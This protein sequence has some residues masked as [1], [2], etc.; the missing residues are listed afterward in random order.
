M[1]YSEKPHVFYATDTI[2][3]GAI[4]LGDRERWNWRW[5]II[6]EELNQAFD[7]AL[8]AFFNDEQ[9]RLMQQPPIVAITRLKEV[10]PAV[11]TRE[12]EDRATEA[13]LRLFPISV[14]FR[15][16]NVVFGN[17]GRRA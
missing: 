2:G 14:A 5:L 9:R 4:F 16:G 10:L 12:A 3:P 6:G 8:V 11:V 1:Y 13:Q 17:F 7:N 15:D